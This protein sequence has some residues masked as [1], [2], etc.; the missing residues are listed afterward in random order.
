MSHE[1]RSEFDRLCA[2]NSAI[3]RL[4]ADPELDATKRPELEAERERNRQRMKLCGRIWA[5]TRAELS[6]DY[7]EERRQR[8]N[9]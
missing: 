5:R 8:R 2:R 6:Q 3:A 4:L 7:A 1:S 9:S